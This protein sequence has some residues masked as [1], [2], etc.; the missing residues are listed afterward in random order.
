MIVKLTG[1]IEVRSNNPFLIQRSDELKQRIS[2]N[3]NEFIKNKSENDYY[4]GEV[5]LVT[6][7]KSE[8]NNYI[9]EIGKT[10]YSDLIYI[11]NSTNIKARSLFVASYI[12]TTDNYY[13]VIKDKRNRINTIGG[14]ADN[15]DFESECFKPN[16]CLRRE[17]FEELGLDL[18]DKSKFIEV[19]AKY[20]KI[21]INEEKHI[22]LYPVGIIY[23][24]RTSLNRHELSEEF[25]KNKKNTDGETSELMFYN[26]EN[27]KQLCQHGIPVSYIIELFEHL[28]SRISSIK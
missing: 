22:A 7:I 5:F 18:M 1:R 24:I 23:E 19:T 17:L 14:L 3:W 25:E 6:D 12:V 28:I 11:R 13:C 4:N 15:Q 10:Q 27:Y 20:I 8:G 21:P 9:F 26:K 2:K 16:N